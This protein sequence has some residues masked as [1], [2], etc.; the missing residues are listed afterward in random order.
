MGRTGSVAEVEMPIVRE[1]GDGAVGPEVEVIGVHHDRDN[2][3]KKGE[4]RDAQTAKTVAEE[5]LSL[6]VEGRGEEIA[7][8]HE[9]EAHEEGA[10]HGEKGAEHRGPLR[11]REVPPAACRTVGLAHVV[12]HDEHD[13]AYPQVVDEKEPGSLVGLHPSIVATDPFRVND[14]VS[15]SS[16]ASPPCRGHPLM[17]ASRPLPS[18]R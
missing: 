3:E 9:E 14:F 13:E 2:D 16:L 7:R 18:A 4:Q 5:G 11:A 10:V 17:A 8:D 1:E 15:N 6:P 12:G